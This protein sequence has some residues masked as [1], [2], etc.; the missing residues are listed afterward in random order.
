[1]SQKKTMDR[2]R[3]NSLELVES[4]RKKLDSVVC[5]MVVSTPLEMG[6]SG[7]AA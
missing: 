5:D 2:A 6:I 1:M 7:G 3:D 4:A